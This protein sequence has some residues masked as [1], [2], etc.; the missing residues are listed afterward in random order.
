MSTQN[1]YRQQMNE[2]LLQLRLAQDGVGE[3]HVLADLWQGVGVHVGARLGQA[4]LLE[5]LVGHALL[6]VDGA[7]EL[8]V[9][10][11]VEDVGLGVGGGV[12]GGERGGGLEGGGREE[13]GQRAR[14]GAARGGAGGGGGGGGGGA[15][16][17]GGEGGG[18]RAGRGV[19]GAV[20]CGVNRE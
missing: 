18:A 14:R 4:R 9:E 13:E 17:A 5:E 19:L 16:G 11:V 15:R 10:E 3:L 1:A 7:E 8:A 2:R 20:A 12:G 6:V